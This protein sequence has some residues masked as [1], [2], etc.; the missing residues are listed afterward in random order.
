MNKKVLL[1]GAG[2]IAIEYS[3]V[4]LALGNDIYAICRSKKSSDHFL[5]NTGV[6]PIYGGLEKNKKSIGNFDYAIVAVNIENLAKCTNVL[7]KAGIKSILVEKPGSIDINQINDIA[8]NAK[9]NR[10]SVYIA[11]NR[12]FYTSV[13]KA[14]ELIKKDGGVRSFNFEFTE[15]GHQIAKETKHPINVKSKWVFREFNPCD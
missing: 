12:R 1:I 10:V 3:K 4:L 8:S 2:Q 13:N 9:N 5:K 6:R 15:F 7:I 14:L 11:Y